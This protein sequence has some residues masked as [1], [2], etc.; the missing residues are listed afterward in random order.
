MFSSR[1]CLLSDYAQR[2]QTKAGKLKHETGFWT[3]LFSIFKEQNRAHE[4][5]GFNGSA[6]DETELINQGFTPFC[7]IDK[8]RIYFK[9]TQAELEVAIKNGDQLWDLSDWGFGKE[10]VIRFIAECYF[11]VTRDDLK[12]DDEE[13]AVLNAIVGYI[14]PTAE[15][16]EMARNMVYW[17]LIENVIEDDIVTEDETETMLKIRQALQLDEKYVY[18][19]HKRALLERY[20]ELKA[21]NEES[22][23]LDLSKFEKLKRM[24]ERLGISEEIFV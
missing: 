5:L 10:F 13:K 7:E 12:I 4:V 18:Q 2:Y 3:A 16:V 6:T 24:A 11:M 19:L 14:E 17:T 9:K 23:E 8:R 22:Q 1:V 15:E 20:N 21:E